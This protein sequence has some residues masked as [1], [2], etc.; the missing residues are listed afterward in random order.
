METQ[1]GETR[2]TASSDPLTRRCERPKCTMGHFLQQSSGADTADSIRCNGPCQRVIPRGEE[3]I[4]CCGT[5]CD[6]DICIPCTGEGTRESDGFPPPTCTAGHTLTFARRGPPS[7]DGLKCDGECGRR[8]H[9]GVWRYSCETCDADWC[10]SCER[11]SREERATKRTRRGDERTPS[12]QIGKEAPER[13]QTGEPAMVRARRAVR[14]TE[15]ARPSAGTGDAR[16]SSKRGPP[17]AEPHEPAL[18]QRGSRQ[19]V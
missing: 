12:A 5:E 13:G 17:T 16:G 8:I 19:R 15:S 4:S 10:A 7:G 14:S 11:T 1:D 9:E 6:V 18:A 2:P 3:R